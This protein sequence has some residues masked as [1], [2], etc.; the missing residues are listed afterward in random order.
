MPSGLCV[1][2]EVEA[3][4]SKIKGIAH[5]DMLAELKWRIPL[6]LVRRARASHS[7]A[8]LFVFDA[9]TDHGRY[10]RLDDLPEP[11]AP[12]QTVLLSLPRSDTINEEN[13]HRFMNDLERF[14][15]KQ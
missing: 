15:S 6:S 9:D 4:S 12:G 7:P 10:A 2:V 13:L 8:L 5:P 11:N 3:Y 14:A 1:F